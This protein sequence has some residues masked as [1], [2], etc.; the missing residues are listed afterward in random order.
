MKPDNQI[1]SLLKVLSQGVYEKEHVMKWHITSIS[2]IGNL[3]G[4]FFL[5]YLARMHEHKRRL[6]ILC[7]PNI[8]SK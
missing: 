8:G 1:K 5:Y 6:W 3:F 4:T 2:I 7:F